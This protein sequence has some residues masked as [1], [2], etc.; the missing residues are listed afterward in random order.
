MGDPPVTQVNPWSFMTSMIWG[1]T[2][3]ENQKTSIYCLV[4]CYIAVVY[5]LVVYGLVGEW[6]ILKMYGQEYK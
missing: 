2:I 1:I 6:E 4:I 5:T 3:L